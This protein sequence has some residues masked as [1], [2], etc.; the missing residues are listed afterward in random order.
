MQARALRHERVTDVHM[1]T[2][3]VNLSIPIH[4]DA[5]TNELQIK[6]ETSKWNAQSQ[7]KL[8]RIQK[9][10]EH[11]RCYGACCLFTVPSSFGWCKLASAVALAY[12]EPVTSSELAAAT[13][14]KLHPLHRNCARNGRTQH[15]SA[16]EANT[17]D[18]IH[19]KVCEAFCL[20]DLHPITN[21]KLIRQVL[22]GVLDAQH[23]DAPSAEV[24]F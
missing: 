20:A 7:I 24:C 8:I 1:S 16:A 10:H 3:P 2:L 12:P 21:N 4:D 5:H 17:D 9:K 19:L 23:I 14:C 18:S 22:K 11:I 13:L 15:S 6:Q